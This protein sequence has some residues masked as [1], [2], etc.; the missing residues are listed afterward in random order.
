M[1]AKPS[2]ENPK[3]GAGG[4]AKAQPN[5]ALQGML[6]DKAAQLE[7]RMKKTVA[8]A[9]LS[10]MTTT[11]VACATVRTVRQQD[12]DTWV[13]M[14]VEAL[15]THS[16]FLTVPM[17]RTKTESGIEIRNY[18]NG[19]N[20][21]TC[22]GFG[23]ANVAGSWVNANAFSNCSSGWVGCKTSSTSR[24]GKLLST[25]RPVAAIPMS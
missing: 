4:T 19:R 11:L 12:L 6:R 9:F 8:V 24:R 20:F 1:I 13:G 23:S 16:F 7:D 3:V 2:N 21:G 14:P 22:S 25:H 15:D 18:A 10:I 17:L 5:T